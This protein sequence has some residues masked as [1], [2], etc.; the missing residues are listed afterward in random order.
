MTTT[1]ATKNVWNTTVEAKK[2]AD[3][4]L[5]TLTPDLKVT[6]KTTKTRIIHREPV[7]IG[8]HYN[9]NLRSPGSKDPE[10]AEP[11]PLI[12]PKLVNEICPDR[13]PRKKKAEYG[14]T[15]KTRALRYHPCKRQ[16][17]VKQDLE[18]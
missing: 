6:T 12:L 14:P 2:A 5:Q 17:K 4:I 15:Q 16:Q 18:R 1:T 9:P 11:G 7:P 10:A 8:L 3:S 13:D